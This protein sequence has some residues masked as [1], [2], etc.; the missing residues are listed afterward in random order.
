MPAVEA[1]AQVVRI[2]KV[3]SKREESVACHHRL[4]PAAHTLVAHYWPAAGRWTHRLA[5]AGLHPSRIELELTESAMMEHEEAA[6]AHGD[7][8]EHPQLCNSE[9]FFRTYGTQG[10][11]ATLY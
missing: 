3:R 7:A 9:N 8:A 6:F 4:L 2:L 11:R 1:L 5:A 10:R